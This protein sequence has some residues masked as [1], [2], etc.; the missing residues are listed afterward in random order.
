VNTDEEMVGLLSYQRAYEASARV[1][2]AVDEALDVL[3]NRTGM[4]GR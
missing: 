4:V 2:T 3:I 1:I